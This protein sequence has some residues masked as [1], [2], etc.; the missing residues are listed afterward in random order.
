VDKIKLQNEEDEEKVLY[1]IIVVF[2]GKHVSGTPEPQESEIEE[3][4]WWDKHPEKV[5]YEDL[6]QFTIPAEEEKQ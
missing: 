6:K 3:L 5:L 1:N 4:R 2:R